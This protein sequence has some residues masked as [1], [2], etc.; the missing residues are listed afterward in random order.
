MSVAEIE[1]LLKDYREWLKDRTT[2]DRSTDHRVDITTPYLDRHNDALQIYARH[3]NG[4]FVLTDE[5]IIHDLE[6]SGCKLDTQKRKDLLQMTLNGCGV[7]LNRDAIEAQATP[8]NFPLRSTISFRL[9]LLSTIFSVYQ[10]PLLRACFMRTWFIA[11]RERHPLYAK[12]EVY[13][14]QRL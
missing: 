8:E 1:K 7:K 13:R 12:R 5:N 14:H 4:G 10:N 11:G 9:C 2:Y 3:E 6:S